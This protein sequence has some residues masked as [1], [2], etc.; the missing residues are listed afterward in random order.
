M[1]HPATFTVVDALQP[2]RRRLGRAQV[3]KWALRGLGVG[4][5][6]ALILLATA[7]VGALVWE[8][9][10][11]GL[12]AMVLGTLVGVAVGARR[13][14]DSYAAAR[15]ADR[16][17]ALQDRL[18]TALEYHSSTLPFP[19]LQR[20]EAGRRV[21]G[22]SLEAS[23]RVAPDWREFGVVGVLV[24]TFVALLFIG[25]TSPGHARTVATGE[26][27]QVQRV[28]T[29]RVHQITN[30]AGQGLTQST[31]NNPA[32][33]KLQLALERLRRQLEHTST[34]V[35]ALR[36]I[37]ATQV[38]LHQLTV[39]LHPISKSAVAQLNHSL[40]HSMT[41]QQRAAATSSDRQALAA[42]AQ[43]LRKLA[44]QLSQM[45]AAQRAQLARALARAANA[46]GDSH[47]QAS[48]RQAASSLGYNDPQSAAKSLQSAA[49]ALAQTPAQRTAQARAAA[50]N[51]QL[52]SLKNAVSGVSPSTG[53]RIASGSPTTGSSRTGQGSRKSGST[54][55]S[56]G[57]GQGTSGKGGGAGKGGGVGAGQA[58]GTG[59]GSGAQG[60]G[61][62]SG[63]GVGAGAGN[64]QGAPGGHGAGGG[65]GG[66]G[67]TGQGRYTTVYVPYK[68]GK[69]PNT[70]QS[71]PTGAPQSG[72]IVP[73][74]QVV[75]AYGQT[76]H[77]A[78]D[79]ANL[80]PSLRSYVRKYFSAVSH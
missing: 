77:Q 78:L 31:R 9:L 24:L 59:Q 63:S 36:A 8:P 43:T 48:L 76:A 3:G 11:L 65:R 47:L 80:P 56:Q 39:S 28:T 45:N 33:R 49:S 79:R 75:G 5:A 58:T 55:S 6:A 27:R 69:G 52:D 10:P 74:Q 40:A 21:A 66:A 62:E 7:H 19:G 61:K 34:R 57:S 38:K 1:E 41:A 53:E 29:T 2:V 25:G 68:Q 30:R 73:Y 18:T 17:F 32:L 54:G 70:A 37:S 71:G 50:A 12:G 42:A 15:A 60:T 26:Q 16:H 46:T 23:G 51:S 20:D 14:P 44:A 67:H 13:W 4:T 35:A 72:P 64:G 22:L